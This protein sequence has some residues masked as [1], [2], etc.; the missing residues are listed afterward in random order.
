[1]SIDITPEFLS[2]LANFVKQQVGREILEQMNV[3]FDTVH[4]ELQVVATL[5][6]QDRIVQ[7]EQDCCWLVHQSPPYLSLAAP[8]R[9]GVPIRQYKIA[10]RGGDPAVERLERF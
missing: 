8:K 1:M 7:I 6:H 3:L 5:A 4:P 2:N 10:D 9:L